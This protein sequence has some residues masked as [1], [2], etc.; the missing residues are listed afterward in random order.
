MAHLDR[1]AC[2]YCSRSAT[3]VNRKLASHFLDLEQ[4]RD[5]DASSL[6]FRCFLSASVAVRCDCVMMS[7]EH[8]IHFRR[9]AS[10]LNLIFQSKL[11]RKWM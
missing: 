6:F 11:S 1:L 5:C 3:V 4:F 9:C 7:A 8:D 10:Q 2:A